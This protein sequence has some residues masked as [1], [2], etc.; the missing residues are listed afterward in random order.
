MNELI[1]KGREFAIKAH[2]G[3]T[4]KTSGAPYIG[5]PFHVAKILEDAGMPPEVVVAGFLHDVVED[6]DITIEV[7]RTE[8][9]KKVADLVSYNTEEKE[10]SWEERKGHTIT[11]L[12]TGTLHEKSLVVAD[13]YANLLELTR[14]YEKI[15][16]SIWKCFKRGKQHQYWYFDGVGKSGMANLIAEEI[17][18]FFYEYEEAVESFFNMDKQEENE[19]E[20]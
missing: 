20:F 3:Q 19:K 15:G 10:H 1:Q 9:G 11:Q 7:I 4:R 13:K 12:K 8:F 6:T 14:N 18:K 16:D 2:E 5:H 17:P